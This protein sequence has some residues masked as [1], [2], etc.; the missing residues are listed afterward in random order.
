MRRRRWKRHWDQCG[1]IWEGYERMPVGWG[2]INEDRF[3]Y[4][5][6]GNGYKH[7]LD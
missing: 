2:D 1:Y 4:G 3:G 7:E 6:E 5:L